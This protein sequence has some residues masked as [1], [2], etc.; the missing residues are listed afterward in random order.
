MYH[1]LIS[2]GTFDDV[3]K[4]LAGDERWPVHWNDIE[5]HS[6]IMQDG[7]EKRIWVHIGAMGDGDFRLDNPNIM[8]FDTIEEADAWVLA[9]WRMQ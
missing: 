2:G 6:A 9:V 4:L 8:W 5:L 3:M 1:K 7:D